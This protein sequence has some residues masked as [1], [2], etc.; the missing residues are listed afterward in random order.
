MY[1]RNKW[2]THQ[3]CGI[4]IS[5][6]FNCH[7]DFKEIDNSSLCNISWNNS[8]N[9]KVKPIYLTQNRINLIETSRHKT[10]TDRKYVLLTSWVWKGASRKYVR[11]LKRVKI[12]W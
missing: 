2:L 10:C 12:L 3:G 6:K 5:L 11:N 7:F 8:Q 4:P 1:S 9:F